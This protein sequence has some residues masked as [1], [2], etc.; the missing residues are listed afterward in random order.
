MSE[1]AE[2]KA[3]RLEVLTSIVNAIKE[4]FT[5]ELN[6]AVAETPDNKNNHE[7]AGI[8]TKAVFNALDVLLTNAEQFSQT[9]IPITNDNKKE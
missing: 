7:A 1:N 2:N 6:K 9:F 8:V 4:G 5:I 3:I